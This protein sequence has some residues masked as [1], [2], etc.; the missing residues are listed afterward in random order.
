MLRCPCLL[1]LLQG[2]TWLCGK[3]NRRGLLLR[4]RMKDGQPEA[5]ICLPQDLVIQTPGLQDPPEQMWTEA[6]APGDK[7]QILAGVS[8]LTRLHQLVSLLRARVEMRWPGGDRGHAQLILSLPYMRTA[9]H[10]HSTQ[11]HTLNPKHKQPH[12][13]NLKHKQPGIF[14]HIQPHTHSPDWTSYTTLSTQNLTHNLSHTCNEIH[15][16]SPGGGN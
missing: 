2:L 1:S 16:A 4:I 11:P 9:S 3:T 10:L 7:P 15:R 12:T 14:I 13:L 8:W 5:S 6:Q